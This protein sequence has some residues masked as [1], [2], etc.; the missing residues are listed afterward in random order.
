M[1]LFVW[2]NSSAI[3]TLEI[4]PSLI[5]LRENFLNSEL[6]LACIFPH[7]IRKTPNLDFIH[8]A[9][10]TSSVI[11]WKGESQNGGKKKAKHAKFSEKLTFFTL[12]YAHGGKKCS[13]FRK[14]WRPLFSCY[15]H[16]EIP[17]FALLPTT[18]ATYCFNNSESLG[19]FT[20]NCIL[21]YK[22]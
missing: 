5:Q 14:I 20:H 12:W 21:M 9:H 13:F 10:S 3:A 8:A 6:L 7:R 1:W 19:C 18:Y 16:L 17:L 11:R 15:F 22:S 4:V 2:C